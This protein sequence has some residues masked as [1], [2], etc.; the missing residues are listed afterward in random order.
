MGTKLEQSQ[1]RVCFLLVTLAIVGLIWSFSSF[2][3]L[4]LSSPLSRWTRQISTNLAFLVC[5]M[6]PETVPMVF[7]AR[8]G[9]VESEYDK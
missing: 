5:P 3:V 2:R 7:S 4:K 8:F 1:L 6:T 9:E